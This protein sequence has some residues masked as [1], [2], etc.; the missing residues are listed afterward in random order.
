MIVSLFTPGQNRS[1]Q[2]GNFAQGNSMLKFLFAGA[3]AIL[4]SPFVAQAETSD[5]SLVTIVQLSDLEA[6]LTGWDYDVELAFM[7]GDV[8]V[9]IAKDENG[10]EFIVYGAA[11]QT[12]QQAGCLGLMMTVLYSV[13]VPLEYAAINQANQR[14]A[15]ATTTYGGPDTES[16]QGE[17]SIHR[18]VILDGGV[19]SQNL[20]DNLVNLLAIAPQVVEFLEQ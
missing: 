2:S 8:P 17:L 15:A 3:F 4:L 18:Y 13:D 10:I 9:A 14:W 12:G 11:C 6:A 19:S 1:S 7:Q 20:R 5:D 16:G